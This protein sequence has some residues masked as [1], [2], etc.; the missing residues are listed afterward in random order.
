[1]KKTGLSVGSG[2]TYPNPH[3]LQFFY[4]M[5]LKREYEILVDLHS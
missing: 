1:M 5:N 3:Y 4:V 2:L